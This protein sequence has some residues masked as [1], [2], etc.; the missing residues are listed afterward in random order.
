MKRILKKWEKEASI[1]SILH[2][3]AFEYYSRI[4]IIFMLPIIILSSI[5]GTLGMMNTTTSSF[6]IVN[7]INVLSL[8]VGII[9]YLSAMLTT[10]HNYLGIQKHQTQHSFHAIEYSK[11]AREIKMHVF[12][13]DNEVNMYKNLLEFIKLTRNKLD[14]LMETAPKIPNILES[15]LQKKIDNIIL[16][17]DKDLADQIT[18]DKVYYESAL[19]I[20]NN[21]SDELP[22]RLSDIGKFTNIRDA[23]KNDDDEDIFDI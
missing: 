15:R 5:S 19:T 14:K 4:N 22:D 2:F 23:L 10:I 8:F 1:N 20:S 13:S 7:K 3:S 16:E 6:V 17:I 11:I 18:D 9:G 21:A 12:L